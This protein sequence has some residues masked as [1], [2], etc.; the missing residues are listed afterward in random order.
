MR[1]KAKITKSDIATIIL[2]ETEIQRLTERN[3][4]LE[5]GNRELSKI[6]RKLRAKIEKENKLRNV[7]I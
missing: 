2:Q 7:N 4:I 3:K 6:N 5:S 1:G